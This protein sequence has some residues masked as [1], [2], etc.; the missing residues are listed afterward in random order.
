MSPKATMWYTLLAF[1][2][3]WTSPLF[4]EINDTCSTDNGTCQATIVCDNE[5]DLCDFWASAGECANNPGYMLAQCRRSCNV[6]SESQIQNQQ[7]RLDGDAILHGTDMGVA[8]ALEN[9][10]YRVTQKQITERIISSRA[11]IKSGPVK[12]EAMNLCQ[13]ENELCT[14]WALTG[15][16]ENNP[17]CKLMF[18]L[19]LRWLLKIIL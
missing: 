14:V 15:E 9:P 8:Q 5:H 1:L 7:A 17:G 6:C 18:L 13:N 10:N 19:V 16:C 2:S 11:Y 3:L 4:A 12:G